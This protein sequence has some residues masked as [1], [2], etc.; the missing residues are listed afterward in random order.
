MK[1]LKIFSLMM[2]MLVAITGCSKEKSPVVSGDNAVV[3][4]WVLTSWNE[5]AP[6]FNVYLS[7]E[8]DGTFAI[9]QQ[10]WSLDYECFKGT[11]QL[12]G[13]ILTGKY[14]DNSIWASGYKV[15][16]TDNTLVLYSQEDQSVKSVYEKCEIP[17]EIIE[18]ATTTRAAEAVP[19]L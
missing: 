9:Y 15:E 1:S 10:V 3:G 11:Y 12:E 13:S 14:A 17:T 4:Q 19:F 7:F 2:L 16:T 18:E 8:N 6:E 5:E